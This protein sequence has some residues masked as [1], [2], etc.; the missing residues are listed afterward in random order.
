[1]PLSHTVIYICAVIAA[2]N[3]ISRVPMH[4]MLFL[5]MYVLFQHLFIHY[6]P[7][8]FLPPITVPIG[9]FFL[10]PMIGQFLQGVG[11]ALE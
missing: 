1:M 4:V 5:H 6:N 8:H 3:Q 11:E 10:G 7:L 2:R 9:C